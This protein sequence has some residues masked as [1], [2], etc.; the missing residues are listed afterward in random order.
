MID[1]SVPILGPGDQGETHGGIDGVVNFTAAGVIAGDID[2]DEVVAE[3]LETLIVEPAP[4]R[5]IGE[6]Y[7]P[8]ATPGGD[9]AGG[10]LDALGVGQ[11][12][13][14]GALA[15]IEAGPKQA[16]AVLG[17]GPTLVI[18][19]AAD[20]IETDHLGAKLGQ[21]HA[22]KRRRHEGRALDHP[23]TLKYRARLRRGVLGRPGLFCLLSVVFYLGC[24]SHLFPRY[25]PWPRDRGKWRRSVGCL[26]SPSS[27]SNP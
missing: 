19:A 18:K 4:G 21:G 14:D 10:D 9:Q 16:G 2:H 15:L 5:E 11:I 26:I 17:H 13:G 6:E 22:A 7:A 8:V 23:E 27:Q 24:H 1:G 20:G 3:T 25:S 12:D